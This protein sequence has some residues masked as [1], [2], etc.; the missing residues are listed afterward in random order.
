MGELVSEFLNRAVREVMTTDPATVHPTQHLSV[1]RH[2]MMASHGHHVPVVDEGRFIGLLAPA[3]LLRVLPANAYEQAPEVVDRMLDRVTVR[4]AMQEDVVTVGPNLALRDAAR[5]LMGGG[6][7][8]LPVVDDRRHLLGLLTTSD[9][10][11]ALL[12]AGDHRR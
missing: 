4:A 3:D 8:C 12:D 9:L 5:Q 7:H 11:R 6:F 2:A 10:V 1:V